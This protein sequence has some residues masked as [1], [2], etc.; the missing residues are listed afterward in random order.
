[1]LL[2]SLD[3]DGK[4]DLGD[5]P[6]NDNTKFSKSLFDVGEKRLTDEQ[7]RELWGQMTGEYG[8]IEQERCTIIDVS[9]PKPELELTALMFESPETI[10]KAQK[11]YADKYLIKE[12]EFYTSEPHNVYDKARKKIRTEYRKGLA[13]GKEYADAVLES[14]L[15][16]IN[17]LQRESKKSLKN[18]VKSFFSAY[19]KSLDGNKKA[20]VIVSIIVVAFSFFLA[21]FDFSE[22]N[23]IRTFFIDFFKM[24]SESAFTVSIPLLLCFLFNVVMRKKSNR[25]LYASL[26]VALTF[27]CFHLPFVLNIGTTQIGDYYE[28]PE[29]KEYYYVQLSRKPKSNTDRKVYTLPA[30]IERTRDYEYTTDKGHEVYATNYHINYLFF[31]NGGW[32][33]FGDEEPEENAVLLETEVEMEDYHN[34]TYYIT[35]T[36]EKA[37]MTKLIKE[38]SKD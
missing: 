7:R 22:H 33:Y 11:E 36:K 6:K 18:K 2:F 20:A 13:E 26:V 30:E 32:L 23:N 4:Y 5:I 24:I 3:D 38:K 34:N 25:A 9:E 16:D 29:Y 10:K 27:G 1:M 19:N 21:L 37:D 28:L 15:R 35:L 8:T 14:E 17:W 31:S 12:Y